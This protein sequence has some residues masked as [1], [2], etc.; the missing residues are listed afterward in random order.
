M[1]RRATARLRGTMTSLLCMVA[2]ACLLACVGCASGPDGGIADGVATTEPAEAIEVSRGRLVPTVSSTS[3]VLVSQ[4]FA[5]AAPRHGMFHGGVADGEYVAAGD[6]LGTVDG[7]PLTAVADGVVESLASDNDV[8][9][10]YPVMLLRY[11]GMSS[12]VD[13]SALLRTGDARGGLSGRFQ[14]TGGQGPTDCVAVVPAGDGTAAEGAVDA[15]GATVV[16]CLFPKDAA[17][18][19]GQSVVTVVT[20]PAVED[21]LLLPVSAVAG[22]AGRG[23]VLRKDGDGY[24]LV[25]VSLGASDGTSIIILDGLAEGDMVSSVAPNLI[26]GGEAS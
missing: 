20:A 12:Q 24:V 22:R 17:V 8:A 18:S 21:A 2:P 11:G 4:P 5:I 25:D 15:S 10:G 23:Q 9:V 7:E 16:Q 13:V 3:T 14:V 26:A 1:F 6:V 19:S